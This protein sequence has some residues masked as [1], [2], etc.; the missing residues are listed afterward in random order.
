MIGSSGILGLAIGDGEIACA[1]L[2]GGGA[3]RRRVQKLARFV[4]PAGASLEQ[5]EALGARLK[6][7]L[8]QHHLGAT[9]AVVGVPA[10]WLL[11]QE[12]DLP[13]AAEPQALAMLRL[14]AERMAVADNHE[15]VFDVA[16]EPDAGRATRVLIV[17]MLQQHLDRVRRLCEAAGLAPVAI[18]ATA[19]ALS[20]LLSRGADAATAKNRRLVLLSRRGA[21]VVWQGQGAPRMLR[22]LNATTT[23]TATTTTASPPAS[24]DAGATGNP[25]V[26][27]VGGELR[28]ALR[29]GPPANGSDESDEVLLFDDVGLTRDD[30]AELGERLGAFVRA[31][32]TFASVGAEVEPKALNGAT[33][34]A[35]AEAFLP[36]VALAVAGADR[37]RGLVDFLHTRLAP[38]RVS[39]IKRQ[40]VLAV[41]AAV[42]VVVGLVYLY[43]TVQQVEADV[44]LQEASLKLKADDV[45]AA[46]Q[47]IDR[48]NYGRGYFT[49]RPPVLDCLRELALAFPAA[50][51]IWTT[52]FTLRDTRKGQLQGRAANQRVVL[53]VLD[54]LKANPKFAD[55]QLQD[56]REA[57]GGAREIAFAIT[58]VFVAPETPPDGLTAA[59]AA[60]SSP[61]ATTRTATP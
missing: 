2:A 11:A 25:A 20:H 22:H 44:A 54:R 26:A 5:P 14:Q 1:Q 58:F 28:R 23:P 34:R 7:F 6:T 49:A 31:D 4:F 35:P 3:A 59:A 33:G 52:S 39:R 21:E 8:R 13:P 50:D 61:T 41:L 29:L 48:V 55:V 45:K 15:L 38:P 56:M 42:A 47:R 46:Q 40:T 53:S 17:G 19:L 18:T 60:P 51:P 37:G 36:A 32:H 43:V 9:R 24:A 16:G 30:L 12:K 27:A 10:K 57:A